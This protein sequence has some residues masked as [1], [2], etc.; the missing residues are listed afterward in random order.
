[1]I[2]SIIT[3]ILFLVCLSFSHYFYTDHL[4]LLLFL[5]LSEIEKMQQN[6]KDHFRKILNEHEK[7]K[8]NVERQRK[9]LEMRSK[10]LE[11]C[12]SLNE[13]E[14]RKVTDEKR[15]VLMW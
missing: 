2:L 11:K 9:V 10:E 8:S 12:E 6:A 4:V 13:S 1:M 15:K 3:C 14:R 7:F 5:S